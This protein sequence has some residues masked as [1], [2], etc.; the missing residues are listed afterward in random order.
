MRKSIFIYGISV[1]VLIGI[2][3]WLEYRYVVKSLPVEAYLGL[4]AV[5]CTG[6]GIWMGLKWMQRRELAATSPQVAP[7]ISPTLS[8]LDLGISEREFE[9]LQLMAKG[10]S[11]QEIADQLYI[12]IHTVKTHASNL[13]QKLDVKRRTQALQKAQELQII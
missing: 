10:L 5:I 7:A 3:K 8:Y 11:N 2:M 13:Y 6:L 9:V 12:S 4:I 1:A